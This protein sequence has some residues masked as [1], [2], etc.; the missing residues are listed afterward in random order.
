MGI[1][2]NLPAKKA[3]HPAQLL[4]PLLSYMDSP[5]GCKEIFFVNAQGC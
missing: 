1:L 3:C 4:A 5:I 2:S